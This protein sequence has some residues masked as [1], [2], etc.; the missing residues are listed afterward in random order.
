MI[1]GILLGLGASAC[2]A[3]AN[4]AVARAGRAVG[5]VRALL[6][7]QL[8]GAVMAALASVAI[9]DRNLALWSSLGGWLAAAGVSA[10]LAYVCLFYAFEHGKLTIAVPIMSS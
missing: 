3:L 7:A 10:L 4:V 6:W 5:S 2:W 9:D 1:A 8:S